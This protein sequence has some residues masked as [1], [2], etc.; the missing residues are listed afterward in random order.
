MP[1]KLA[2]S[3]EIGAEASVI[4]LSETGKAGEICV[5]P[6]VNS[7]LDIRHNPSVTNIS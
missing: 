1:N 2:A 4:N 7:I 3:N 6:F 5:G